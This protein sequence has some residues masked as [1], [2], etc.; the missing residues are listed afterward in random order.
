MAAKGPARAV[1]RRQVSVLFTDM[2]GYT[3]IVEDLGEEKALAFTQFLYE[4]LA[5]TVREFDGSVRGFAGD[6]IMALF[7]IPEAQEDAAL[8]AC[9]ASLAIQDTFEKSADTFQSR[10]NVKPVMRVGV[11]SGIAMMAAVEGDDTPMTAVGSTVNL[12][13][14]IQS[15]APEGGCLICDA[16]RR[17]VEWVVDIKLEGE[18]LVKGLTKPQKLWQLNFIKADTKRF[19]A[20]LA[21]GLSSF[22]GRDQA[23]ETLT[24]AVAAADQSLQWVDL[25]A[26][27]GLGKTRLI[28]EFLKSQDSDDITVLQGH[29]SADGRQSPLLPFIEVVRR[30]FEIRDSEGRDGIIERFSTGLERLNLNTSENLGLLL[31]LLGRQPP[32]GA[33]NG[34]DGV[35]VGLRTRALLEKLLEALYQRG[36]IILLIEDIHWI[37]ESSEAFLQNLAGNQTIK[38]LVVMTTRRPN[39]NPDWLQAESITPLA[40]KPLAHD[41]IVSMA[42]SWLGVDTLPETLMNR[43][44]ERAGGNPLFSEEI[45]MFYPRVCKTC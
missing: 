27:P 39:Y 6:S 26:E 35:L 20:S 2:V 45:L 18:R 41:D 13:S 31:N 37:D 9:R 15:L 42:Q 7:G 5:T 1:E 23:L 24:T 28:F 33:L 36:K 3:A 4:K 43:L 19:D 12:A 14:R 10:F 34:L 29:C 44:T 38:N 21:R 8:R 32:Q 11:C 16:T 30:V 40:L 17:L 22:V 25:V